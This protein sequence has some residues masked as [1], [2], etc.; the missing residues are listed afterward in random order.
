M[1]LIFITIAYMV[2]GEEKEEG[3]EE[4][5]EKEKRRGKTRRQEEGVRSH[6]QSLHFR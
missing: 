3:E 5:Q 2:L 6:H 1:L 4:N